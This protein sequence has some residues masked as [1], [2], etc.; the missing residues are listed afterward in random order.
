MK[1]RGF[2]LCE[3]II[4][5]TILVILILIIY[6]NQVFKIKLEKEKNELNYSMDVIDFIDKEI[7]YNNM[8]EDICNYLSEK[9]SVSYSD[10]NIIQ[11]LQT[12]SL[13]SL[14]E[15]DKVTVELIGYDSEEVTY[16][17][18]NN[19]LKKEC[20]KYRWMDELN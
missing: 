11:E 17:I 14:E 12:K 18:I 20:V 5:C 13:F 2:S 1:K 3:S 19:N 15:G 8:F 16:N 4:S 6:S 9:G 10:Y 7:K